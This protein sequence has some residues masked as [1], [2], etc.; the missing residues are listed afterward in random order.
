M[1][2][3]LYFTLHTF[4]HMSLDTNTYKH[5]YTYVQEF[6]LGWTYVW[7]SWEDYTMVLCNG[8]ENAFLRNSMINLN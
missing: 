7:E 3:L 2:T 5:T 1:F 4:S 8:K 6:E